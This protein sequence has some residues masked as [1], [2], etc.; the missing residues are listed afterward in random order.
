MNFVA[1]CE[2]CKRLSAE[3]EAATMQ[4]FR[5]QGQLRVAEYSRDAEATSRI[6]AELSAITARRHT[7]REAVEKHNIEAHP[8]AATATGEPKQ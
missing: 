8:R 5:V 4:W 3:Y 6:I 7:L 1:G 2:T